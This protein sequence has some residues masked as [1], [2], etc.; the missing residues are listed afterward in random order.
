MATNEKGEF[1]PRSYMFPALTPEQA[2]PAMMAQAKAPMPV[3]HHLVVLGRQSGNV[4]DAAVAALAKGL[5][6]DPY[7]A[8]QRVATPCPRVIRR[9]GNER[10]AQ[11]WVAWMRALELVA[12]TVPESMVREFA[13]LPIRTFVPEPDA[14]VFMLEDGTLRRVA[15]RELLC[16]VVGT[17]H[18]RTVRETVASPTGSAM[19]GGGLAVGY[20]IA[21]V[22]EELIAD[23]HV[24]GQSAPMRLTEALLDVRSLF[25]DRAVPSMSHMSEAVRMLRMAVGGVPVYDQFAAASGALGDNWQVLARSTNLMRRVATSGAGSLQLTASTMFG[26]SDR[27]SFDLYS[28]LLRLQLLHG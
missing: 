28:H 22:S 15:R 6:I 5:S 18:E 3:A 13:P 11:R 16:L 2:A 20:D 8:R 19:T 25:A 12:F 14:L 17:I 23:I 10:E 9:E 27:A 1:T 4:S 24:T 21:K 7:S 26:Q